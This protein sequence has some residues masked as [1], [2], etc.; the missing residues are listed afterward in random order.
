MKSLEKV[1]N[2]TEKGA[3]DIKLFSPSTA[4][5][6]EEIISYIKTQPCLVT[7]TN[8][9]KNHAQ[10]IIDILLGASVALGVKICVLDGDNYLFTKE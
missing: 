2:F 3:K 7:L 10:R 5:E 8:S 9:K 4:S 6:T 1:R